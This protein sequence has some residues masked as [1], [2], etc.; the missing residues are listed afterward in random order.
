MTK[1]GI[2]VF[3]DLTIHSDQVPLS[4]IRMAMLD[5]QDKAWSH[6]EE[7]EETLRKYAVGTDRED[8]LVFIYEGEELPKAAITLWERNQ[9][10]CATNIV[11]A[12]SGQLTVRE[13]NALLCNFVNSVVDRSNVRDALKLDLTDEVRGLSIWTSEQAALALG[14][15]SS[16]ANKST[17]NS[18]PNDL[19]RWEEFVIF[20]HQSAK[21]L[22]VDILMQW[23]IEIDGWDERSANKLAINYEQGIS[24]LATYDA[25]LRG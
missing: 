12:E 11:P 3:R 19:Q 7:Q 2:E 22:P 1:Q 8:V 20:A 21:N 24:L 13:Y 4:A 16:L 23:L 5:V 9:A 25:A 18:H 14:R 10:Y 6:G 17:T 15:F